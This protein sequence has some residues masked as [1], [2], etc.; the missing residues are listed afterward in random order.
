VI[1]YL[2][3]RYQLL[4]LQLRDARRRQ[5]GYSTEVAIA[6]ALLAGLALTVLG[7]IA[8]KV[9]DKANSIPMGG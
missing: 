5:S 2:T 6:T 9:I 8:A 4:R 7:I 1:T 3:A